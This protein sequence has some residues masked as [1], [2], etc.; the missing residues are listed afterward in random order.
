MQTKV[1]DS[2][3]TESQLIQNMDARMEI[4]DDTIFDY[5]YSEKRAKE[6]GCKNQI[7]G[8]PYI[9]RIRQGRKPILSKKY[10][11]MVLV[12]SGKIKYDNSKP[13]KKSL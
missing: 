12:Y 2:V 6:I 5:W 8:L 11:D 9:E 3:F 7:K 4:T 1:K 13:V 10:D